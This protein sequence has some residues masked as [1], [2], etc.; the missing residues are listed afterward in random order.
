MGTKTMHP[1]TVHILNITATVAAIWADILL[2]FCLTLVPPRWMF[3]SYEEWKWVILFLYRFTLPRT[4]VSS[5]C[6]LC[7][8]QTTGPFI[9]LKRFETKIFF[10]GAVQFL[11]C[12]LGSVFVQKMVS[13]FVAEASGFWSLASNVHLLS[14]YEHVSVPMPIGIMSHNG[15]KS[16]IFLKDNF[17]EWKQVVIRFRYNCNSSM[18]RNLPKDFHSKV[19]TK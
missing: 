9:P 10:C 11:Y 12:R 18:A 14:S 15:F 5:I 7:L 3:K 1:K 17:T 8:L 16:D 4:P 6:M 19:E 2:E 13:V